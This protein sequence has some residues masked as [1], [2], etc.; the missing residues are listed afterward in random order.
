MFQPQK[1]TE[2][3]R[4]PSSPRYASMLSMLQGVEAN[5]VMDSEQEGTSGRNEGS[6]VLGRPSQQ[7]FKL[8]RPM[9][10]GQVDK[11]NITEL[12]IYLVPNVAAQQ[13][14]FQPLA[15][16]GM[17]TRGQ[18]GRNSVASARR[19][20]KHHDSDDDIWSMD[21]HSELGGI[22]AAGFSEHIRALD[23]KV[24]GGFAQ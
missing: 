16:A 23:V 13:E 3:D 21:K 4:P 20:R 7:R 12:V 15:T 18:R 10:G 19:V 1:G 24:K 9:E 14:G 8:E 22:S 2:F 5:G 17:P 6:V 11:D